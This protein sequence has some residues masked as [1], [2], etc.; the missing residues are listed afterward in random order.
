MGIY[1]TVLH[2]YLHKRIRSD[3]SN[4][5]VHVESH[6]A[7]VSVSLALRRSWSPED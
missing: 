3:F 6:F 4:Y 2:E 5:F 1:K 7:F